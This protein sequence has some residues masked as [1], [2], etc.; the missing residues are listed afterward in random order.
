MDAFTGQNS[1]ISYLFLE[2]PSWQLTQGC[3]VDGIKNLPLQVENK[4]TI[5]PNNS[6]TN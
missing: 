5:L 1:D 6:N 3:C 2:G 4:R